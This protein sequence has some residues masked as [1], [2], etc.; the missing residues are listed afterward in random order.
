[1]KTYM[2]LFVALLSS[3]AFGDDLVLKNGQRLTWKTLSDEGDSYAVIT[4]DGKSLT[5]KK[6]EVERLA[7]GSEE[8]PKPLTG[9]SFSLDMKKAVTID[10]LPK[11][12]T[13]A[14]NGAWKSAPGLLSNTGENKSRV[15]LSFDCEVP[16]EY[17]LNIRI[18][19]GG[20]DL[21]FEL[22]LVQGDQTG[23]FHFDSFHSLTSMFGMISG[24]YAT[25]MDG[26]FFKPGKA[27]SIRVAVRKDAILVQADGKDFWKSRVDWKAVTL[28]T[29]VPAPE[30]R[31]LFLCAAGGAWKVQSFTLSHAK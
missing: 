7:L 15:T 5:I 6:S 18:E 17:D 8:A 23:A 28:F 30:K 25:K 12:K 14:T 16:E 21:G 26:Q 20:G 27:R 4:K 31:K 2:F 22:G 9:A 3:V 10:L 24:E 1:M 11:A 19:R 29:D 13:E